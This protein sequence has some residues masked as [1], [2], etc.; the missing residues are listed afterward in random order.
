M[1]L[2]GY[3]VDDL[4]ALFL[5]GVPSNKLS[6]AGLLIHGFDETEDY[7]MPWQ[8]C[9]VAAKDSKVRARPSPSPSPSPSPG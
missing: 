8:P 5:N 1:H 7:V 9:S 3:S 6:E 2:S 4:T